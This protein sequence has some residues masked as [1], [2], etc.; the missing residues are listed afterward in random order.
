[1]RPQARPPESARDRAV[2]AAHGLHATLTVTRRL[3]AAGWSRQTRGVVLVALLWA[4]QR[5]LI[6]LPDGSAVPA[7]TEVIDGARDVTLVTSD[8]LK[9][10]GWYVPPT[11]QGR[12]VTVLVANGNGGDRSDRA[13]LASALADAGFAVLLFD[14]RGY[15]RNPGHPSEEGLSRD[16]RAAYRYLVE[17][18]AVS[19]Q[20]MLYFGESLGAGVVAELASE[21]PPAGLLLRSPFVDL[22]SVGQYHYPLVP[23]RLL[24]RDR[25]PVAELVA[26]ITVPTTIVYGTADTIIPPSQSRQVAEAAAGPVTQV[27]LVGAGHNDPVM[28]D[29][30]DLLTAVDALGRCAVQDR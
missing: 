26:R 9:L 10:G 16:V 21:H 15:G 6:Y 1:M 29:G 24:L 27:E 13:R 30:A 25:Y 20:R 18:M 19:P 2:F 8:G 12:D 17:E 11:G 3:G 5:R 4:F 22:A 23:V 28:F 14:Y 7:A